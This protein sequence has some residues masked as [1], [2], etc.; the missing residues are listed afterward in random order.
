M[1]IIE[2][3]FTELLTW[4]IKKTAVKT[5]LMLKSVQVLEKQSIQFNGPSTFSYLIDSY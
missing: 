5:E 2:L 4:L 1:L 3:H